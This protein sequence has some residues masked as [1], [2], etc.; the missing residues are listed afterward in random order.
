MELQTTIPLSDSKTLTL[1]DVQENTQ[2]TFYC[3]DHDISVELKS[4]KFV[5]FRRL[6]HRLSVAV[7]DRYCGLES[8]EAR[9]MLDSST[10]VVVRGYGENISV[11]I[12][13]EDDGVSLNASEWFRLQRE[14]HNA[15]RFYY[16][17]FLYP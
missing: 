7:N 16:E 14:I 5:T 12:K 6:M 11:N 17:R 15:T 4:A 1:R 8:V 10:V 9:F 13:H 2:L 3:E